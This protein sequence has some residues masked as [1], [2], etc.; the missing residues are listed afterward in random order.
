MSTY[1]V[2]KIRR[3]PYRGMWGVYRGRTLVMTFK[4][5][6]AATRDANHRDAKKHGEK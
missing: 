2:K 6:G 5:K 4:S 3:A 1:R